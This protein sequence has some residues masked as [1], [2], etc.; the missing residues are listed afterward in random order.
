MRALN[1]V[2]PGEAAVAT[3]TPLGMPGVPESLM[4]TSNDGSVFL[5]WTAPADDGGSLVTGYEYRYAPGDGVPEDTEWQ[6]AR[7]SL[8]W[9]VTGL[10]NGQQYVF[11]VR[12]LNGVGPG[13]AAV[14]TATPLGMPGVPESLMATSND[15]S[16]FLEWT[17]PAD[18][19][20]SPVTGYEYRYAPGDGVPEDTEW[21][22]ARLSLEWTVTGLTNGQQYVFEV[23]ALN[24]VGPGEAA[25]AT[26]TPLGMPGVPES[27]MA[28]S[29]DGSVFLEWT[30]PADDGGS[31]VTGYEYRYAPGD[32]VPEDTEWQDARL[33]LEWT[34]TGLTNGQQYVFEVRA[35]NGVGPGEAAVA[36]A[37]TVRLEAE[38]F[39]T[40]AVAT[41][42]EPLVIGLRRSGGLA[43]AAH[44]YVGVT[45]SAVPEATAEA[46]GRSDGLGRHRLEFAP[47]ATEA[48]VTVHPTFDGERGEG[49]VITA[50]LESVEVEI[51]G[52]ARTYELV[53]AELAFP[54]TDADAVM[55]VSDA[56]AD[57][58]SA[59][60]VFRMSLDRTRD[61]P[62]RVDYATENG[63]ARAGDDYT[64]AAGTLVIEA[65]KREAAVEVVVLAAPH[66]TG[67]RTLV[68]RLSNAQNARIGDGEAAGVIVRESAL[69]QAWLSRFG[70]AASDHTAQ[71]IARRLEAGQRETQVTV[72]G[73][74]LDGLW[75][76]VRSG[77]MPLGDFRLGGMPLGG[78]AMG[79]VDLGSAVN[80][81]LTRAAGPGIRGLAS[82]R[83][84]SGGADTRSVEEEGFR[85]AL[86]D[87][88]FRLPAM[89]EALLGSS[90]YV[91]SGAQQ[92][93]GGGRIWAAWGNVAATHFEGAA[94]GL[95][96][97]GDVVTATVGLDRQ[98]RTLLVGLALSRSTGEGAYGA[99]AGTMTSTLT[100][101]H[102]YLRYRLAERA[103]LWGATG[104][105]RGGMLLT[106]GRG[107]AIE[108][109]LSA[110]MAAL[111]GR[112]VLR[113]TGGESESS[114]EIAMRSDLLWTSTSSDEAGVLAEATGV[115]SRGR[116]ILEG[117]G[118]IS[119]LGGVLRPSVEGG[120]RYDGG[121]AETGAGLEVGT[122]LDWTRGGLVLRING[123][124]LLAYSDDSYEEW[125]YGGSLIY[126]S[127]AADGRGLRMQLGSSTGATASG[128][129]SLWTLENASGLVLGGDMPFERRFDA[130]VGFGLGRGALWYPYFAADATGQKR[131]G[132]RLSSGQSLE[133][134]LEFGR[135]GDRTRSAKDA[136]V[137]RG[138]IRF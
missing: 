5:E 72:A 77:E 27:L 129:R 53:T 36:T 68:L 111:G 110:A 82:G 128:V 48:T 10:T 86:P 55:S 56:R 64:A 75:A 107:A 83:R 97:R 120:M 20:G 28:T 125:G 59:A 94:S 38:L 78:L 133:V 98:W 14:A 122:G 90:F 127:G 7:L 95:A 92:D 89:K 119:G 69:A 104:W 67:E 19:G 123:R 4:A 105:G 99:G 23:R 1:G 76:G 42:G 70:R 30:A 37:T 57:A 12:A 61:V 51:D 15:G 108:T 66:L 118:R 126:E 41:E 34:V 87:F 103:Q 101:V 16:V 112:A 49:R 115:A 17:A 40:A 80:E 21:Q 135:M 58:E 71:A 44:G 91:E 102:P 25:V 62:V 121:D 138:A 18:D 8:E 9:T 114:I 130:E 50:T 106:P 136:L 24:G 131:L 11:E 60:L 134:G 39:S 3:A 13:E 33:S 2:G 29:N 63:T 96:L 32:G 45:D 117:V 79:N 81:M 22:S 73:R 65:G 43:Q 109:D 113:R 116:L 52:A 54:V 124:M 47:R 85:P 88:G 6:G 74:R 31:L 26:A 35:L 100:S 93:G 137:L 132:L 46:A 84:P